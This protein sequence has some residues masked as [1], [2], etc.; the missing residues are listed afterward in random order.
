MTPRLW[1]WAGALLPAAVLVFT[2][3]VPL[4]REFRGTWRRR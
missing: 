3:A 4:V 2:L 1:E